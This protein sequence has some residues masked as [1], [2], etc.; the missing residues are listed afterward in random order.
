MYDKLVVKLNST[1]ACRF[2]LKTKYG[3]DKSDL[4]KRTSDADKKI[5]DTSG[6][7]K[8]QIRTQK[9]LK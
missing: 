2:V 8:K 5:D 6:L 7:A 1:D 3:I 4:E 9:L